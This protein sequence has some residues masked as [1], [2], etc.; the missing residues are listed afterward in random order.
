MGIITFS[1]R[2]QWDYMHGIPSEMSGTM[3]ALNKR[4]FYFVLTRINK[5]KDKFLYIGI[6]HFKKNL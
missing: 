1:H 6:Y 5:G 2:L 3:E 4:W